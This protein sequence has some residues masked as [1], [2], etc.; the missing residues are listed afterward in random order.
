V[1][2]RDEAGKL[3]RG[4]LQIAGGRQAATWIPTGES[5]PPGEYTVTLTRCFCALFHKKSTRI[6]SP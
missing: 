6:S 1:V 4:S 5:L 2:V 3:V